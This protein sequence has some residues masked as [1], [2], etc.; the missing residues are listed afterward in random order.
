MVFAMLGRQKETA[1]VPENPAP[2][3]KT[4]PV[5]AILLQETEDP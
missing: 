2:P 5:V 1:A 4:N 3:K